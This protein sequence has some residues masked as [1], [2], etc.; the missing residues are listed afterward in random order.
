[1]KLLALIGIALCLAQSLNLL[2]IIAIA[3]FHRKTIR[4]HFNRHHEY[5]AEL[6]LSLIIFGLGVWG[7][8]HFSLN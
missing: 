1:M 4:L 5:W 8:I 7:I 3:G 2:I 6:V